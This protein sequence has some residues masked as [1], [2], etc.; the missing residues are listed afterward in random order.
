MNR[1]I[2]LFYDSILDDRPAPIEYGEILR[3]SA[4]MDEIF[5]Q[6]YAGDGK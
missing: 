2:S 5:S 4:M 3:V 1:L 6:V